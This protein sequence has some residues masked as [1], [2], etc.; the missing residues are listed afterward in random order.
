ML[1]LRL[2]GRRFQGLVGLVIIRYA[3]FV[4]CH[5]IR[6]LDCQIV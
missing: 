6:Y 3:K 5:Y 2:V 4:A 1:S